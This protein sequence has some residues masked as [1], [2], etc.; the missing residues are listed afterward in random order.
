MN[1]NYDVDFEWF[2]GAII[3]LILAFINWKKIKKNLLVDKIVY[4]SIYIYIIALIA[5]VFFPIPL[6]YVN[7]AEEFPLSRYFNFT[8][9]ETVLSTLERTP[10]QPIGNFLLLLPIGVYY[11]IL[12]NK[13][14]FK[15]IFFLG[16]IVSLIIEIIQFIISIIIG[17][18]FRIFDIDDL[19]LNTF[20]AISGYF[21]FKLVWPFIKSSG[22][23]SKFIN[24]KI[25]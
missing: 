1:W 11:P 21:L 6:Y 10:I 5:V 12:Y 15:N 3:F 22:L 18:P 9:F 13:A 17:V 23:N 20:G 19:I 14:T 2:Y 24:Q 7:V 25:I 4:L 8:P 16:I